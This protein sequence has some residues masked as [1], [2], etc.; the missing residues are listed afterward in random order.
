MR[1]HLSSRVVPV[2]CPEAYNSIYH[3]RATNQHLYNIDGE[4]LN[5][6]L[7]SSLD[8][9][10]FIR[11]PS[12]FRYKQY[13]DAFLKNNVASRKR[14][15]FLDIGC[16]TGKVGLWLSRKTYLSYIGIDFSEVAIQQAKAYIETSVSRLTAKFLVTDFASTNLP[17]ESVLVAF[18]L[19]SIYLAASPLLVI[20]ETCR[21][22]VKGGLL[23][24]TVYTPSKDM[25]CEWLHI[26]RRC[27][28]DIV[29]CNNVSAYWRKQMRRKHVIRWRNRAAIRKALGV[30]GDTELSVTVAMLGK[31][32]HPPYLSTHHRFEIFATK[33]TF[34]PFR[35]N[36]F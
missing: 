23:I 4:A 22:L 29:R 36:F 19:D 1:L 15:T 25:I 30:Q 24:F 11:R 21:V 8:S 9:T 7:I 31:N 27:G 26:L 18:S 3:R 13:I 2:I 20:N 6:K 5:D 10:G 35:D 17:G 28:F 33:M 14:K 32:G 34:V 16:G 12:L